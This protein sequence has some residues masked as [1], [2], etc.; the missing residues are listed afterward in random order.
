MPVPTAMIVGK[1]M[2]RINGL[3]AFK[4]E[5]MPIERMRNAHPIQSWGLYMPLR[6]T[7]SPAMI[8]IGPMTRERPSS[9]APELVGDAPL[10]A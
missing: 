8:S 4:R 1:A 6:L 2:P 5:K 10:H 7:L 9:S 3:L